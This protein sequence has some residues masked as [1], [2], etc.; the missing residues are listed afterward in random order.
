MK[1]NVALTMLKVWLLTNEDL[2]LNE[3]HLIITFGLPISQE[4]RCR[5]MQEHFEQMTSL[6]GWSFYSPDHC[7]VG[8]GDDCQAYG[9][10][11]SSSD[12]NVFDVVLNQLRA[13]K[14]K[15]ANKCENDL[16]F[17]SLVTLDMPNWSKGYIENSMAK[18]K[19]VQSVLVN[20]KQK[21]ST[22]MKE[23]WEREKFERMAKNV[24]HSEIYKKRVMTDKDSAKREENKRQAEKERVKRRKIDWKK[25]KQMEEGI[26]YLRTFL[27]KIR[28]GDPFQT[29]T[30][31]SIIL[32]TCP[33]SMRGF[34]MNMQL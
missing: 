27:R 1:S 7:V 30:R 15:K 12:M 31:R 26:F 13:I 29:Y 4:F 3:S 10:I 8:G 21:V 5:R 9:T 23:K 14:H 2:A 33:L 24:K 25:R 16:P 28:F 20:R 34:Y 18:K 32:H 6:E 11:Y 17:T 22:F 19:K